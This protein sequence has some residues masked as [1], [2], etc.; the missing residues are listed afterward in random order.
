MHNLLNVNHRT[1]L[2]LGATVVGGVGMG[3]PAGRPQLLDQG[4]A[5][6]PG[7]SAPASVSGPP[8]TAGAAQPQRLQGRAAAASRATSATDSAGG[9]GRAK[10]ARVE[11]PVSITQ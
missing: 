4:R 11:V 2:S 3:R 9:G 5:T 1:L 6:T 7:S 10:R 8:A